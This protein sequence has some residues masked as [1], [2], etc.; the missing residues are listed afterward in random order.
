MAIPDHTLNWHYPL[1][2]TCYIS[3][4]FFNKKV[5]N[6]FLTNWPHTETQW[7]CRFKYLWPLFYFDLGKNLIKTKHKR[8]LILKNFF[9]KSKFE[10]RSWRKLVL[11]FYPVDPNIVSFLDWITNSDLEGETWGTTI[12]RLYCHLILEDTKSLS[13][14][15]FQ[16]ATSKQV[17]CR[18]IFFY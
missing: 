12:R 17:I 8:N 7:L 13:L 1:T 9:G 3:L 16:N 2:L 6:C 4:V 18:L 5:H 11:Y 14:I 15:F 10:I